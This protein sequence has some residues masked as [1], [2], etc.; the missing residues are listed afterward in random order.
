MTH[1]YPL[2]A[3]Y[4]A[5]TIERIIELGRPWVPRGVS[6]LLRGVGVGIDDSQYLGARP[7]EALV[8]KDE[9]GRESEETFMGHVS[10]NESAAVWYP[11]KDSRGNGTIVPSIW[12]PVSEWQSYKDAC[13][14]V[15][16]ENFYLFLCPS[17]AVLSRSQL[18]HAFLTDVLPMCPALVCHSPL[19]RLPHFDLLWGDAVSLFLKDRASTPYERSSAR[20]T[21]KLPTFAMPSTLLG[22]AAAYSSMY[23]QTGELTTNLSNANRA[24]ALGLFRLRTAGALAFCYRSLYF[25]LED[26]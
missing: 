22:P 9:H 16:N 3:S 11:Y 1:G 26:R 20:A 10:A 14:A 7:A 23:L 19:D 21:P 5:T 6:D 17:Q 24:A 13:G 15:L 18:S 2:L 4:G 25:T 12:T 8:A